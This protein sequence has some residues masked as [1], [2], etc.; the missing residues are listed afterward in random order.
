MAKQLEGKTPEKQLE[1]RISM[2]TKYGLGRKR[3]LDQLIDFTGIDFRNQ[4]VYG[5]RCKELNWVPFVP[6]QGM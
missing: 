4:K 1:H 3:S 6:D 5:D 2:L